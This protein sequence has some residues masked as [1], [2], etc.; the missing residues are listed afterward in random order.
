MMA[1]PLRAPTP[2]DAASSVTAV[3]S[4]AWRRT[5]AAGSISATIRTHAAARSS[6]ADR[7]P[8]SRLRSFAPRECRRG[9]ATGLPR[10]FDTS[11]RERRQYVQR[12]DG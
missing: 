8:Q 5:I 7:Q 1:T 12:D 4:V 9:T 3:T 6:V 10:S 2:V 11:C